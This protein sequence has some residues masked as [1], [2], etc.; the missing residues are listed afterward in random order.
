[1]S[2]Y[3]KT[4]SKAIYFL[5]S[6]PEFTKTDMA[7]YLDIERKHLYDRILPELIGKP[8]EGLGMVIEKLGRSSHVV[9]YGIISIAR[10]KEAVNL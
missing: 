3:K 1:M 7:K 9:S 6:N 2:N 10:V 4:L 8:P 5:V